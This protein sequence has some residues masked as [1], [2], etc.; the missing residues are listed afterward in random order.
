MDCRTGQNS[1]E[2]SSSYSLDCSHEEQVFYSL[3]LVHA[4]TKRAREAGFFNSLF[5]V[6]DELKNARYFSIQKLCLHKSTHTHKKH[7][8][9]KQRAPRHSTTMESTPNKKNKGEVFIEGRKFFT[10]DYWSANRNNT[11]LHKM[12]QTPA[13]FLENMLTDLNALQR[14]DTYPIEL[15]RQ[16]YCNHRC[17]GMRMLYG[18]H[19]VLW[20]ADFAVDSGLQDLRQMITSTGQLPEGSKLSKIW[21]TDSLSIYCGSIIVDLETPPIF[22]HLLSSMEGVVPLG[23][24]FFL[25]YAPIEPPEPFPFQTE[26][27]FRR[28]DNDASSCS[29]EVGAESSSDD[30]ESLHRKGDNKD[31]RSRSSSRWTRRSSRLKTQQQGNKEKHKKKKK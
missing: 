8:A 30:E 12:D 31:S 17:P 14:A 26:E 19:F 13:I 11:L 10:E 4:R 24:N 2:S 21:E 7:T 25:R 16:L 22:D 9:E 1:S 23:Y 6:H 29:E 28:C 20:P 27:T 15:S 18:T 3:A 5:L